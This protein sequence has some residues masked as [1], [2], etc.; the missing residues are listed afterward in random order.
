MSVMQPLN[1]D[2]QWIQKAMLLLE[3]LVSSTKTA[4]FSYNREF[5]C[6]SCQ[7][8]YFLHHIFLSQC[9]SSSIPTGPNFYLITLLLN[10]NVN[11]SRRERA[12]ETLGCSHEKGWS[13]CK[14]MVEVD[15]TFYIT[16]RVSV[17]KSFLFFQIMENQGKAI[18]YWECLVCVN[19]KI[20]MYGK[21]KQLLWRIIQYVY[22]RIILH[23]TQRLV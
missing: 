17:D 15:K 8:S 7:S 13:Y 12:R 10:L 22:L 23:A 16:S 9:L 6:I 1:V 4:S 2:L 21:A 20:R 19:E 5:L 3:E 18:H 14:V 11:H